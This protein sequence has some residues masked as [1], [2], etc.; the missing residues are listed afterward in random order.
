MSGYMF[1]G[2]PALAF[3]YGW[4]ALWYA[5]GD[6]GGSI[7]NLSVLGKRMRRMS[8]LLGHF[9]RLNTWKKDLKVQASVSL[10]PSSQ[11]FFFLLM[12]VLNL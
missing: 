8:E 7:I 11:L 10:V 2:A 5:I 1:M 4:Y 9:P 3:K 6:A 12:F